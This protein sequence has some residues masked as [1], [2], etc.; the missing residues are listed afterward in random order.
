M[1]RVLIVLKLLLQITALKLQQINCRLD[2]IS[3]GYVKM[4]CKK[5]TADLQ[6]YLFHILTCPGRNGQVFYKV[7]PG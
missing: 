7:K 5:R 6:H 1:A 4:Q 2:E 3:N